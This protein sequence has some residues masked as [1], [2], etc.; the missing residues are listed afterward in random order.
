MRK[1]IFLIS[2]ILICSLLGPNYALAESNT[3]LP[4]DQGLELDWTFTEIPPKGPQPKILNPAIYEVK[5]KIDD[6]L[7]FSLV[8]DQ[9]GVMYTSDS[10]D[11]VHAVY[12]NGKEKWS[13][14]LDMGMKPSVI[15]LVIG[16][17]GT[18]YAYNPDILSEKGFTMIYALS[19]EGKIKWKLQSQDIYSVFDSQFAG[20]AQGNLVFFTNKGL[21]SLNAKGEINW[22]NKAITTS[23]P[24]HYSRTSHTVD[25]YMDTKGNM[26]L[27]SAL[28]EVISIDPSGA[29]RWR[30]KP[31]RYINR[32]FGFKPYISKKGL[33][34]ILT[35]E[36]LHALNT[37]DGSTVDL[38][39]NRDLNDIQSSG[40][41]TDGKDGYYI[42][43]GSFLK[44]NLDGETIWEYNPRESEK[45]GIRSVEEPLT[46]KEGNV[47]FTTGVGNI[48]VLN[49]DGQE[50]FVLLRNAFWSKLGSLI[51]GKNGNIYSTNAD[52]GLV[53]FGKKQIQ[54]YIDNLSLPLAVPPIN[55]E[56]TVLV[57]F[58][59]LFESFG[60]KVDWDTDS[61]TI[62]G[63]KDGLSIK[64]TI[65]DKTAFVNG[66][67]QQ[68]AE[69]PVIEDNTTFVPLRFVGEAL[70]RKVSW[71]GPSSSINI[72]Q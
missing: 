28:K 31:L 23:D 69:A 61:R 37:L 8:Q 53:S 33:L 35:E 41:P 39:I 22:I 70:G 49:N 3:Y 5:W 36:G 59:S 58:R 66:Q 65:G 20:D 40:I 11:V 38:K 60:L 15:Y 9:Q 46:D 68:L 13:I 18:L 7:M 64:L 2:T 45:E 57:P 56:G 26:Y 29:E 34:Y 43:M 71:D 47:Y 54:V 14:H 25:I 12:P 4:E 44:I 1:N 72:D 51:L 48:I 27:D 30:T 24:R 32:F 50:I 42:K 52:I 16:Q 55:N 62:T 19:P 63:S 6:P 21:T 10:K 67:A 17:D